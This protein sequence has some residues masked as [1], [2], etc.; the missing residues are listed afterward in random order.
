MLI[1]LLSL[2]AWQVQRL[3]W[4]KNLITTIDQRI[5]EPAVDID[6]ALKDQNADYRP[7]KVS[8][9]FE[10]DHELFLTAISLKGEGGYDVG[11]E[12]DDDF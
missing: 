7:I 11:Q 5:H 12:A 1:V 3:Q 6:T 2:G 4:K 8:G 10:H 9:L